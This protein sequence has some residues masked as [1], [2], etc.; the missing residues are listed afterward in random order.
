[1]RHV[2]LTAFGIQYSS[3]DYSWIFD[4][5]K[6]PRTLR[7]LK[8]KCYAT[9]KESDSTPAALPAV[10]VPALELHVSSSW[11]YR[12]P[13]P[14]KTLECLR[15]YGG[16]KQH[17]RVEAW[18]YPRLRMLEIQTG[19]LNDPSFVDGTFTLGRARHAYPSSSL[20]PFLAKTHPSPTSSTHTH[21]Q[22]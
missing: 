16:W 9:P 15:I 11:S 10:D 8:I 20:E 22:A 5:T 7:C 19:G 6:P 2:P 21:T 1:M 17:D 12:P 14:S 13:T 18:A 4:W 3:L